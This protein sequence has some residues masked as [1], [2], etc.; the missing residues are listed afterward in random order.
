MQLS[1]IAMGYS[2]EFNNSAEARNFSLPSSVRYFSVT[3]LVLLDFLV[4]KFSVLT[5]N[6]TMLLILCVCIFFCEKNCVYNYDRILWFNEFRYNNLVLFSFL[7]FFFRFYS[8][9]EVQFENSNVVEFSPYWKGNKGV[10]MSIMHE[11]CHDQ[12]GDRLK[13][14]PGKLKENWRVEK[15]VRVSLSTCVVRKVVNI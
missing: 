12:N 3:R 13:S 4:Y 1:R 6:G 7:F 10:E 2:R 8:H 15:N 5:T 11:K 14:F 9:V